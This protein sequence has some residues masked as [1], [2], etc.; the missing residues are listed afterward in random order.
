[1]AIDYEIVVKGNSIRL[2]EGFV[3]LANL[4]LVHTG[5]GPMLFDVGHAPNRDGLLAGLAQRGLKTADVPRVFLSHL[6]VDHVMNI[7]LFPFST[8]VYVS[9]VEWDYV[10]NPNEKDP[11]IPWLIREQLEK[12]DLNLIDGEGEFEPGLTYIGLPG[13]T[14]GCTALVLDTAD[15]GRVV[16]AGDALKFP[17][18]MIR[19]VSD[20][21]FD[22]LEN[23]AKSIKKIL[24]IADRIVPGH[25]S[26]FVR[27]GDHFTWEEPAQMNLLIR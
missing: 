21:A 25:F 27:E 12:Y 3:G 1:M 26:E 13:H 4:T 23:S 7:G 20:H 17:K 19:Q 9:R 6:H 2:P 5:E 18:E 24:S 8:K 22:S 10:G 15:K 14:P 16:L 11:F